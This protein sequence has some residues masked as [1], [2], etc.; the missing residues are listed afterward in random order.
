[1][2]WIR[3]K[4]EELGRLELVYWLCAASVNQ[5]CSICSGFPPGRVERDTVSEAVFETCACGITKHFTG[6]LCEMNK[7]NEMMALLC[8]E[9]PGFG[10]VVA[11]D[12]EFE[13]F[14]GG[15]AGCW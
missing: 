6:D 7:F 4:L 15:L 12:E 8:R 2:L 11:V 10:Q 9:V 13:I 14:D 3:H 5:H 1:M